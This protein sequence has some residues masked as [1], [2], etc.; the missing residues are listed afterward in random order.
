[1]FLEVCMLHKENHLFTL[2]NGPYLNNTVVFEAE[3][4]I[5]KEGFDHSPSSKN[6][7]KSSPLYAKVS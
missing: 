4:T 1:M 2:L 5:I 6:L 3:T 7:H